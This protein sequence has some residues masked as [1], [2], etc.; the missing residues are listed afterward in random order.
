M[1]IRDSYGPVPCLAQ[2][3]GRAERYAI[4]EGLQAFPDHQCFVTDLLALAQEGERWCPEL[5]M[6]RAKRAR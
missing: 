5:E 1:C 3:V 6:G 2:A 4:K